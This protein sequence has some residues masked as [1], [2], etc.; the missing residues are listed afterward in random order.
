M[1]GGELFKALP[2]AQAVGLLLLLALVLASGMA[3]VMSKYESRRLF[4][5]MEKL[6]GFRDEAVVEWGRLQ[7]ELATWA[8]H[9]RIEELAVEK[10]QMRVPGLQDIQ[11]INADD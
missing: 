8:E 1:I 10:L 6:R 9:G 5:E 7:I 4:N 2:T 3:V 11:V